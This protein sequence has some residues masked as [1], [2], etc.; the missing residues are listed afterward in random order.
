MGA[1]MARNLLKA[2]FALAA[3]NRSR[4]IAEALV[5]AGAKIT[6]SA[7]AAAQVA[8]VVIAMLANGPVTEAVLFGP[9]E[10]PRPVGSQGHAGDRHGLV[11]PPELA[12]DHARRFRDRGNSVSRRPGLGRGMIGAAEA[13]LAIMVGG[14]K[15]DFARAEAVF[16]ALGLATYIGPSGAGQLAK[17]A[18]QAIVAITVGAV[19]EALLLAAASSA[20]PAAVRQ[21][22]MGV[23]AESHILKVYGNRMIL[24]DFMPGGPAEIQV[25]DCATIVATAKASGLTLPFAEKALELFRGLVAHCGGRYD[26]SALLLELERMNNKRLGPGPDRIPTA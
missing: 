3:W 20:D 14:A 15:A 17:L 2:G 5:S 21:A 12:R 11:P 1:P 18:N 24:R 19:A 13:S 23:F 7:A 16:A 6:A 26:H 25:K 10:V 4:S 8:D 22:M 9:G